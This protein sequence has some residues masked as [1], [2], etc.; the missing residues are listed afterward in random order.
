MT[1]WEIKIHCL[2]IEEDFEK[3]DHASRNRL[4]KAIRKKLTVEPLKH[5]EQLRGGL[6]FYRKL[7]VGDYRVIYRT[8]R[9]ELV[10]FVVKVGIKRD[11]QVYRE[12]LSRIKKL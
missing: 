12:L 9:K 2:V 6:R 1:M 5:G 11:E 8:V 10:V 4:L 7:R 3:I